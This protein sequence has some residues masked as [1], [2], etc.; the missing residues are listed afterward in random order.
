MKKLGLSPGQMDTLVLV[1]GDSY[2]VRSTAILHI[3]KALGGF[4]RILYL[5]ILVPASW[6]DRVYT[7]IAQKRY[8]LFGKRE[9]CMIPDPEIR[10]RFL[11]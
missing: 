3:F 7:L 8:R 10:S 1:T 6:R 4:W 5:F 11:E 2:L 9:S